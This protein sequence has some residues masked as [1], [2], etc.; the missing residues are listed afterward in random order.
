MTLDLWA[1]KVAGR[2]LQVHVEASLDTP[3]HLFGQNS[4]ICQML[5]S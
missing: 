5:A 3:V 2:C 4:G 1:G